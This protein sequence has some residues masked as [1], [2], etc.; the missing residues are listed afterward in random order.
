MTQSS[1]H[2]E[3][4]EILENLARGL[5]PWMSEDT[6][7]EG[8]AYVKWVRT[9]DLFTDRQDEEDDDHP[10]FTGGAILD[11]L[12]KQ[13]MTKG[14]RFELEPSEKCWVGLSIT[15]VR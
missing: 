15:E 6:E 11:R 9:S 4:L 10:N 5:N 12:L 14:L 2:N 7:I 8:A 13:Y 3:I 1:R